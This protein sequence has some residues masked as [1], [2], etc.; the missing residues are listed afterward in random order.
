MSESPHHQELR[1]EQRYDRLTA[2]EIIHRASALV[3]ESRVYIRTVFD[4]LRRACEKHIL[5]NDLDNEYKKALSCVIA[6]SEH[7][8]YAFGDFT[9]IPSVV[10][11][12]ISNAKPPVR[13]IMFIT[14]AAQHHVA[15]LWQANMGEAVPETLAATR[16]T[17]LMTMRRMSMVD[18]PEGGRPVHYVSL[19][20]GQALLHGRPLST[21]DVQI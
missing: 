3:G 20:P 21:V 15:R 8:R 16:N 6:A 12:E 13:D 4:S 14:A 19:L 7:T 10:L 2:E 17:T 18:M 1:L 9:P 5:A 11:D